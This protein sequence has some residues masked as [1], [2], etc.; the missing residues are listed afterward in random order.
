MTYILDGRIRADLV[1]GGDAGAIGRFIGAAKAALGDGFRLL[2]E[3][4]TDFSAE[5]ETMLT[6]EELRACLSSLDGAEAG[7]MI[8]GIAPAREPKTAIERIDACN[9]A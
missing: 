7:G 9:Q 8:F 5:V 6:A 4:L 3:T 2:S 1:T